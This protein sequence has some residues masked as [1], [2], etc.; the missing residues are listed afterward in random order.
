MKAAEI[1][2]LSTEEIEARL[3]EARE[4]LM[5]LR[6]QKTTGELVDTNAPRRTRRLIARY[7]TILR[8]RELEEAE[9]EEGE[10]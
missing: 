1:R 9:A 8:E 3:A 5:H 7:L 10:A 2:K 6:F 4:E